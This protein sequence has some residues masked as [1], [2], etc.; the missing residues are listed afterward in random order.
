MILILPITNMFD[1][2]ILVTWYV[3]YMQLAFSNL[4]CQQFRENRTFLQ[5]FFFFLVQNFE[6]T[7]TV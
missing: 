7:L 4:F 2:I 6:V 1:K 3:D 5:I